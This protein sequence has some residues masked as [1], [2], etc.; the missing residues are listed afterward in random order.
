[1][2]AKHRLAHARRELFQQRGRG[3]QDWATGPRFQVS[4][5]YGWVCMHARPQ[6]ARVLRGTSSTA[7]EQSADRGGSALMTG[8]ALET[9]V[10]AWRCCFHA[11]TN[12]G[13]N[14]DGAHPTISHQQRW[15]R[16]PLA[17]GP[18]H[19]W[20]LW[21]RNSARG[22]W[23]GGVDSACSMLPQGSAARRAV[24]AALAE[25]AAQAA[26]YLHP[27]GRRRPGCPLPQ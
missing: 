9:L 17:P 2:S 1:M 11:P 12:A 22:V 3:V 10:P 6:G 24:Q 18:H 4:R 25:V 16:R 8:S 5:V 7:W 23:G 20:P 19:R 15:R 27:A 14:R 13:R 26:P 21:K